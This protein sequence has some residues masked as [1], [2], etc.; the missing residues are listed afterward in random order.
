M[1]I[2][3][4]ITTSGPAVCVSGAGSV[5]ANGLYYPTGKKWHNAPVYENDKKCLLSREPHKNAKTGETSYGWII[6]QDRKPLYA[7][8]TEFIEPPASGWKKFTGLLPLPEIQGPVDM[9]EAAAGAATALKEAGKTLFVANRY[10]EAEAVFTRGLGVPF[11]SDSMEVTLYSNRAETRLRLSKWEAALTD[12]E[13]ALVKRPNHDKALLRAAVA[14]RELKMYNKAYDLAKKCHEVHPKLAEAKTLILDLEYLIEDVLA[15]QPDMARVARVKLQESIQL[16]SGKSAKDFNNLNGLKAFAGYGD[17][18]EAIADKEKPPPL[19]SLP[20]HNIG[21]PEDQVATMDKFFQE[22]RD[23][24]A[25]EKS[26]MKTEKKNYAKLKEEY[27]MQA[28]M[29]VREGRMAPLEEIFTSK[30][31]GP[32]DAGEAPSGATLTAI[33]GPK[34]MPSGKKMELSAS[35]VKEIDVLFSGVPT[36]SKPL[37][38]V[39]AG[40]KTKKAKLDKAKLMVLGMK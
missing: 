37:V 19:E 18:R 33:E 30:S 21:L 8:K 11:L 36:K 38:K 22:Q 12:A 29:D 13:A 17:K 7:V 5:D 15:T 25:E 32:A 2:I 4:S 24:K 20:Y 14:A 39:A 34:T 23:K 1:V 3:E 35:E 28:E 6:G 31:P 16:A 9:K 40:D 27:K 10:E 26:K